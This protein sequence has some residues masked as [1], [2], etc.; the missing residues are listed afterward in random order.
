MFWAVHVLDTW[1]F[2]AKSRCFCTRFFRNWCFGTR[3]FEATRCK[4]CKIFTN[5][6]EIIFFHFLVFTIWPLLTSIQYTEPGLNPRLHGH[7][8]YALTTTPAI[9]NLG[10]EYPWGYAR[11]S[12]GYRVPKMTNFRSGGMQLP[13]GRAWLLAKTTFVCWK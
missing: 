9:V 13:K 10:Y 2:R 3:T 1:S 6:R 4:M 11:S 5:L 7:E 8:P 12:R